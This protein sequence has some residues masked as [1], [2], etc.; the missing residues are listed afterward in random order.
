MDGATKTFV[1]DGHRRES[2]V[3]NRRRAVRGWPPLPV[4]A[5]TPPPAVS[6][7]ER[8]AAPTVAQ[9]A[10]VGVALGVVELAL[11]LS[12]SP[13]PI[14]SWTTALAPI[15]GWL[16]L[17]GAVMGWLPRPS[18][19]VSTVVVG[20]GLIWIV[21]AFAHP[22]LPALTAA[23]LFLA[24][25]P[26]AIV[27]LGG[28]RPIAGMQAGRDGVRT[29]PA[30]IIEA[31]DAERRR[32]ARDLHD[33]L[34]AR[35]VLLAVTAHSLR[36]NA[37]RPSSV[38]AEAAELTSGLET[39]ISELREVV[40]GVVPAALTERGLYA[41]AEELADHVPIPVALDLVPD[42]DRLPAAVESTGYFVVSEALTNAVKHSRARELVLRLGRVE[43][44]L[45]IEVSD[46]GVGGARPA[47]GSGMRGMADR[48]EALGG[49]LVV[50]SPAGDGTSLV[51]EVPCGS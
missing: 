48:V 51:A 5:P 42:T 35:L 36:A 27:T 12:G 19:R 37:T 34:Q 26:F 32:I 8:S 47:G 18:R 45:R 39:A 28:G 50:H 6:H 17:T 25:V 10:A 14:P 31:A 22:S 2:P 13:P 9:L 4:P 21:A 3:V 16:Y 24:T 44:R 1:G 23:G 46:D 29:S 20:G 30:R 33:G 40:Q 43:E 49:R 41:A 11:V 7:R 15:V 38:R